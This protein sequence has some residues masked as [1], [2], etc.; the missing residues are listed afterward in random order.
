MNDF[1]IKL[2]LYLMSF[3]FDSIDIDLFFVDCFNDIIGVSN[4][5]LKFWDV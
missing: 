2:L 4:D 3:K 5:L 1:E